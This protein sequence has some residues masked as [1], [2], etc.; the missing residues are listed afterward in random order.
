MTLLHMVL[1]VLE[2]TCS[3]AIDLVFGQRAQAEK[4][5]RAARSLADILFFSADSA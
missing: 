5:A 3:R 4:E 2:A 1:P